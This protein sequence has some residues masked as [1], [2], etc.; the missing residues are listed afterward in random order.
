MSYNAGK[1]AQTIAYFILH[2]E[3]ADLSV[4]KAANLVYFADRESIKSFGFPIQDEPRCSMQHGPRQDLQPT[5]PQTPLAPSRAYIGKRCKGGVC[6]G[7]K[8]SY[9]RWLEGESAA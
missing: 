8:S 9:Y 6:F 7:L 4:L 5:Q 3:S 1:A 2:D